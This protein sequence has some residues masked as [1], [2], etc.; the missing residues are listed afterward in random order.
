MSEICLLNDGFLPEIDGVVNVM[1]NYA[2]VITALG[3]KVSVVTPEYPGA[4]D[5]GLDYPVIRYKSIDIRKAVGY[6]MGNPFSLKLLNELKTRDISIIHSH[7]PV[8]STFV[9]REAR[10]KLNAPF[11]LTYHTRFD[12]DIANIVKLKMIKDTA[13]HALVDNI[14]TCDELWTVSRSAGES[15][16]RIGYQGDYIVMENGVD[17]EKGRADETQRRAETWKYDLPNDVP[18]FLYVGRLMWYKGIRIILDALS[19][20]KSQGMDFRMVFV[21]DGMDAEQI[22]AYANQLR[23][24]DKCF[25]T[26]AIRE[27]QRIKAW[28]SCADLFLFPSTFDT[29]GLVVREAAACAL[30]SVLISG[31]AAAEGTASGRNCFHIEENAASLAVCLARIMQNRQLLGRVG[32]NAQA[33]LYISWDDAVKK[34]MDRYQ[35]VLD[36]YKSGF[37]TKKRKGFYERTFDMQK[38]IMELFRKFKPQSQA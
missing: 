19:G 11:I 12:L 13:V 6:T 1:T 26:G 23:L 9:A 17:M 28:Y 18:L 3:Q 34:A 31:S 7:C 8:I 21:G 38:E 4:D 30:P 36:N 16:K 27:R 14:S 22:K 24:D 33:D 29:N 25:F 5:S 2:R 37:Y 35:I 20:L 10:S 32:E 15:L